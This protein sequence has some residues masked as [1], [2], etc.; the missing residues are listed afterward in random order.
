MFSNTT[1]RPNIT[2]IKARTP[3]LLPWSNAT[4]YVVY[5][6]DAG[7]NDTA[8]INVEDGAGTEKHVV[9][10]P[11]S[12]AVAKTTNATGLS[13]A[14]WGGSFDNIAGVRI[15]VDTAKTGG[16]RFHPYPHEKIDPLWIH[17]GGCDFATLGEKKVVKDS[18]RDKFS[19]CY[20]AKTPLNQLVVV[21]GILEQC[22]QAKAEQHLLNSEKKFN[23]SRIKR[24]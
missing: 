24:P 12:G 11:G 9:L 3:S 20:G 6:R 16:L 7:G 1:C 23:P 5:S 18:G 17:S 8:G 22:T 14:D 19:I 13:I 10:A 15:T 2:P 4:L 21:D